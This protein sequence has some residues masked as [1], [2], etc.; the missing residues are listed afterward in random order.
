MDG[1]H[2]GSTSTLDVGSLCNSVNVQ[3]VHPSAATGLSNAI[4]DQGS[5][6]GMPNVNHACQFCN[7]NCVGDD[8][9]CIKCHSCE[10][11]A[12]TLCLIKFAREKSAKKFQGAAPT[13]LHDLLHAAGLRFYCQVCRNKSPSAP[14]AA[15][16]N[17]QSSLNCIESKIDLLIAGLLESPATLDAASNKAVTS[18]A[19]TSVKSFADAAKS[20]IAFSHGSSNLVQPITN[21]KSIVNEAVNTAFRNKAIVDKG[22][23]SIV[24]F[25]LPE[26]NDD[27]T[28]IKNLLDNISNSYH[29]VKFRR[30]GKPST[31]TSAKTVT[32]QK[33]RVRPLLVELL[34]NIEQ[35][36]ILLSA[37]NLKDTRYS[38]V[39]IRKWLNDDEREKDK[40]LRD[41]CLK[42]N[43]K[44]PC[45]IEGKKRFSVINGFIRERR[46]NGSINFKKEI[47]YDKLL[48]G[49]CANA[50]NS[51]ASET[52]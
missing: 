17:T 15:S 25:G 45:N 52:E 34:D 12:H 8:L 32:P 36:A 16:S 1:T 35:S 13:W 50:N 2:R 18:S 14:S 20:N 4:A 22:L 31:Q 42:L 3:P 27:K 28:D 48:N 9:N 10:V 6:S 37:K 33:L 41:R 29:L 11:P 23:A 21:I 24:V 7:E 51:D 19:S 49:N 44:Y 47:N 5:L 43:E 38:N 30:L 26:S 46:E 39:Y 40:F